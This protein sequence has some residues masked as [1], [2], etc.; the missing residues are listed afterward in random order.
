M[1]EHHRYI[2]IFKE[3]G[4]VLTESELFYIENGNWFKRESMLDDEAIKYVLHSGLANDKSISLRAMQ[5]LLREYGVLIGIGTV[6]RFW[7]KE[8]YT[9]KKICTIAKEANEFEC[10]VF[11]ELFAELCTSKDQLLW[12]DESHRD[13]KTVNKNMVEH[14]GMCGVVCVNECCVAV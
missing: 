13:D 14:Q 8:N 6:E 9:F 10:A 4:D 1:F 12:G 2:N 7:K 5:Q 3:T 11:W